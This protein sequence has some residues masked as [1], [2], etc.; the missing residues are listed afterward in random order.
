M[1]PVFTYFATVGDERLHG[2]HAELRDLLDDERHLLAFW[3][4]DG[5]GERYRGLVGGEGVAELELDFV[6]VD[7]GYACGLGRAAAVEKGHLVAGAQPKHM[8]EVV[9]FVAGELHGRGV[10]MVH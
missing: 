6:R 9:G 5:E 3:D 8:D 2:R 4:G 7:A 10:Q 1:D